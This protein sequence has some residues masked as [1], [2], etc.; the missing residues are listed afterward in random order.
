MVPYR[1]VHFTITSRCLEDVMNIFHC[2]KRAFYLPDWSVIITDD[3]LI[4]I[5]KVDGVVYRR[6]E[7]YK[8]L[9]MEYI[10]T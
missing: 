7:S 5:C 4:D 6:T 3:I 10:D 2:I 8:H 1:I 9:I